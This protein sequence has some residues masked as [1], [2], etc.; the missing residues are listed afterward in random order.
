METLLSLSSGSC[1]YFISQKK[2]QGHWP[3]WWAVARASSSVA[4]ASSLTVNCTAR[5][6][7]LWV[8]AALRGELFRTWQQNF[9]PFPLPS[10]FFT[11]SDFWN[12][13]TREILKWQWRR[14]WWWALSWRRQ[15]S[16]R[17][18]LCEWEAEECGAK[19][20]AEEMTSEEGLMDGRR[21]MR[22][23]SGLSFPLVRVTN[24]SADCRVFFLARCGF[25]SE[26]VSSVCLSIVI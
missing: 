6:A 11:R 22:R 19:F 23:W 9:L 10:V 20:R 13:S 12:A 26:I 16:I 18:V 24:H 8:I 15:C 21:R 2:K 1:C 25:F 17:R 5:L 14:R 3:P 7:A 4:K